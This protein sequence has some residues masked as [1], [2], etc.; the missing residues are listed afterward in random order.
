[1]I[2]LLVMLG[3]IYG[4]RLFDLQ[5]L[6]LRSAF[7]WISRPVFFPFRSADS[8][9]T[10]VSTQFTGVHDLEKRLRT[11]ES[12]AATAEMRARLGEEARL[13]AERLKRALGVRGKTEGRFLTTLLFA[14]VI[15]RSPHPLERRITLDRGAEHGVVVDSPV[16]YGED[17]LGR[18]IE[19][20]PRTSRVL[21]IDDPL[22][23]IGVHLEESRSPGVAQG[24][25]SSLL[26]LTNV[27][28]GSSLTEGTLV[29]T[30]SLSAYYPKGLVVGILELNE[31]KPQLRPRR[32]LVRLEEAFILPLE[33]LGGNP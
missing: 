25:G 16:I 32:D 3:G 9:A 22:S 1:L 30:G 4:Q 27:P 11:A 10:E 31:G 19:V 13:E 8:L 17:V 24:N 33:R 15:G 18:I 7:R 21:L 20:L 2:L 14:H 12:R 26:D 5:F 28:E 6:G 29:L 23:A